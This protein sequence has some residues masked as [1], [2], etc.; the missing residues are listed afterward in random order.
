MKIGHPDLKLSEI[1]KIIGQMWRDLSDSE[2]QVYL[3]DY[4]AEKVECMFSCIIGVLCLYCVGY[5]LG[6][7]VSILSH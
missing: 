2:K 1:A 4:D 6:L 5:I 3:D 7:Y